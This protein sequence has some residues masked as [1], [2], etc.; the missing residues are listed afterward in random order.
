MD[1]QV[2]TVRIVMRNNADARKAPP[3]LGGVPVKHNGGKLVIA[4]CPASE[5]EEFKE[6][7]NEENSVSSYELPSE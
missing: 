7:L 1:K 4:T 6:F 3:K 5:I 2:I